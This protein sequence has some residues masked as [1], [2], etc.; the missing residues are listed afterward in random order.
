MPDCECLD[1]CPYFDSDI[2]KEI[3]T[4]A[5]MRQDEYCKGDFSKCARYMVYKALGRENV[6]GDLLPFRVQKAKE[7]IEK[8]RK[9]Q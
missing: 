2:M 5:K 8:K 1:W 3:G 4:M 9:T 6:P 7:L